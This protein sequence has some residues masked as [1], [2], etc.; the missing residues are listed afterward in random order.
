MPEEWRKFGRYEQTTNNNNPALFQKRG[1]GNA[2][3]CLICLF[4][5]WNAAVEGRRNLFNPL[6]EAP[7]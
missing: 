7:F 4:V 5:F 6:E 1:G 2:I 3:L